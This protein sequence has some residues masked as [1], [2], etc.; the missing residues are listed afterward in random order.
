MASTYAIIGR[1]WTCDRASHATTRQ[2]RYGISS[3]TPPKRRRSSR[4][5]DGVLLIATDCTACRCGVSLTTPRRSS[6]S[7][8]QY[9]S[10]CSR[11]PCSH[12]SAHHGAKSPHRYVSAC[13]RRRSFRCST[14]LAPLPTASPTSLPHPRCS[15]ARTCTARDGTTWPSMHVLTTAP[16]PS[17]QVRPGTVPRL[18]A[19]AP[20]LRGDGRRLCGH[21]PHPRA[22]YVLLHS[23]RA[24]RQPRAG[25]CA[26]MPSACRVHA[27]CVLGAC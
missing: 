25:A 26:C 6:R 27:E 21:L 5:C 16:R 3:T 8:A 1:T 19:P 4:D 22:S 11:R 2:S 14:R 23:P 24:F 15:T 17:P 12:A 13:S 7:C 20:L 9:V 10:A 18:F